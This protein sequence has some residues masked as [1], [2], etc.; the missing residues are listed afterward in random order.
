MGEW[1]YRAVFLT[2]ALFGGEWSA[3]RIGRF[4]PG[5]RWIGGWMDPRA[6]LDHVE[7]RKFLTLMGLELQHFDR[8]ARSQSLSRLR[9]P[10]SYTDKGYILILS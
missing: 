6:G 8:P 9:Y 1:M 4:T 2:A 3:S 5:S 10:G 7:K